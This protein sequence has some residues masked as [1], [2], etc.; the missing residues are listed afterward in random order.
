MA[1]WLW[2]YGI[3]VLSAFAPKPSLH[4]KLQPFFQP[5]NFLIPLVQ[6]LGF[7]GMNSKAW[8]PFF[9][10]S[11]AAFCPIFQPG[12]GIHAQKTYTE[13]STKK[14]C[15][16]GRT[17]NTA[18]LTLEPIEGKPSTLAGF[19]AIVFLAGCSS[20]EPVTLPIASRR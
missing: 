11:P 1:L 2:H 14:P 10:P 19:G 9:F 3:L 4:H 20:A 6:L 18:R 7:L 13:T 17:F 16:R 12:F 8:L 5:P 15:S